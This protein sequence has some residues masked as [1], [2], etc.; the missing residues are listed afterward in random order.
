VRI[1]RGELERAAREFREP[2][3]AENH[4]AKESHPPVTPD[5][6]SPSRPGRVPIINGLP[7]TSVGRDF[8]V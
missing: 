6:A 8:A 3:A 4:A 1:L 2:S 7:T 5:L